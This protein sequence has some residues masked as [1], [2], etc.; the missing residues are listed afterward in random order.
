[1][2]SLSANAKSFAARYFRGDKSIQIILEA[3]PIDLS[4]AGLTK[5]VYASI[6][7]ARHT[8]AAKPC[9]PRL[10]LGVLRQR[11]YNS[12]WGSL[13]DDGLYTFDLFRTPESGFGG[14]SIYN[15][16][17]GADEW[18]EDYNW[19]NADAK[20]MIGEIDAAYSAFEELWHFKVKADP[21]WETLGSLDF[22]AKL[23]LEDF[24][25]PVQTTIL[26]GSGRLSPRVFGT[27][28]RF[29]AELSDRATL[30]Y[31]AD[32]DRDTQTLENVY[33]GG[34]EISSHATWT[35]TTGTFVLDATP[36]YDVTA[37]TIGKPAVSGTP[38]D[39]AQNK[40]ASDLLDVFSITTS[41]DDTT[42]LGQNVGVYISTD[43]NW[44]LGEAVSAALGARGIWWVDADAARVSMRRVNP[45]EDE[46]ATTFDFAE[47]DVV[48]VQVPR[49]SRLPPI[50]KH[51]FLSKKYW[52]LPG[53]I[54]VQDEDQ[55]ERIRSG[56]MIWTNQGTAITDYPDALSV[57]TDEVLSTT[58]ETYSAGV[59]VDEVDLTAL[60]DTPR[61]I[62]RVTLTPIN[63]FAVWIGD[64]VSVT[65]SKAPGF[66]S[67]KNLLVVGIELDFQQRRVVLEAF[68]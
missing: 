9:E 63:A 6:R 14:F 2:G 36:R 39:F 3:D 42:E 24:T 41:V 59:K 37:T 55:V 38:T 46:G 21:S 56:G 34:A 11:C 53:T 57:W 62:H 31:T 17:N 40:V 13:R 1:M 51:Q 25:Q 28:Y 20:L 4:T 16:D 65:T 44:A 18:V 54:I 50:V 66:G 10:V 15:A 30:K 33:E 23:G 67:G 68:G 45:P 52:A 58:P 26:S 60:F 47:V 8:G 5:T 48:S 32:A 7:E 27:C 29:K 64:Y 35:H 61:A 49:G 12:N 19:Q 43:H 22:E